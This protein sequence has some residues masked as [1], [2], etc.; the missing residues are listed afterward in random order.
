ME[1]AFALFFAIGMTAAVLWPAVREPPIDSFPL[2]NYPMFSEPRDRAAV[3]GVIGV[4]VD[5]TRRGLP[6]DVVANG[7]FMQAAGTVGQAIRRGPAALNA[8]CAEVAARVA[9]DPR[10][11]DV[12]KVAIVTYWYQPVAYFTED[13][14]PVLWKPHAGCRVHR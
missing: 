6:P 14:E 9:R 4:T 5:D 1:R 8:L 3:V 11:T 7:E 10:L 12:D 2:S 13:P